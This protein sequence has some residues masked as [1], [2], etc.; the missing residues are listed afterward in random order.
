MLFVPA[1]FPI[2]SMPT[3]PTTEFCAAGIASET[4]MPATTSGASM[5]V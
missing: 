4:P 1:A 3:D 5:C 2:A